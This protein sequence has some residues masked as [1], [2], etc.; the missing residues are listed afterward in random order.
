MA[1]ELMCGKQM[2]II[3]CFIYDKKSFDIFTLILLKV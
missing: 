2:I 1:V 3:N